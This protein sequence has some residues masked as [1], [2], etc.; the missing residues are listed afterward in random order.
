MT[1]SERLKRS[2]ASKVRNRKVKALRRALALVLQEMEESEA[3]QLLLASNMKNRF[4][5]VWGPPP[6]DR[7]I[8][9]ESGHF[10]KETG[11]DPRRKKPKTKPK[12]KR[13]MSASHP[14]RPYFAW[15]KKN[16]PT[17]RSRTVSST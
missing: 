4:K 8:V 6:H 12:T 11:R 1:K 7:F 2:R 10:T 5:S 17:S 9:D 16:L 15:V 3:A 13:K 14:M